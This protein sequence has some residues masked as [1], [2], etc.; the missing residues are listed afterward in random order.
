MTTVVHV[1]KSKFDVYIGRKCRGYSQSKWGNPFKIEPDC[2][3][4][5]SINCYEDWVVEQPGLMA[6]LPELRDKVL[7]CWCKPQACHG[8][9]LVK[10][11]AEMDAKKICEWPEPDDNGFRM[12]TPMRGC[13]KRK[14]KDAKD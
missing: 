7:G 4:Q 3:R 9:V 13:V 5:Q 6:A 2:N 8:D 11:L 10:L 12:I 14:V 1:N